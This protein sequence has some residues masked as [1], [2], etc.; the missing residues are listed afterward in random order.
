MPDIKTMTP[1]TKEEW[2]RRASTE[3]ERLTPGWNP[4]A[5][6]DYADAL[7]EGFV[8]DSTVYESDPEDAVAEDISNWD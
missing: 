3:L 7:Y 6:A 5:L 1:L 4:A 2:I 8:T